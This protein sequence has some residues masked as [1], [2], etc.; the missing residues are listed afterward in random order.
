MSERK[1]RINSECGI[2]GIACGDDLKCRGVQCT[3]VAGR[4]AVVGTAFGGPLCNESLREMRAAK[5]S[6]YNTYGFRYPV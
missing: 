6:P 3:L 5:G 4:T 2:N 1:H